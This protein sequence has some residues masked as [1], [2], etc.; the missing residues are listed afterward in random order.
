MEDLSF[1][2]MHAYL[3][4]QFQNLPPK[5]AMEV[6]S[7]VDFVQQMFEEIFYTHPEEFLLPARRKYRFL[8]PVR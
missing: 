8:S 6:D 7:G 2:G 1:K 3:V 4:D 5:Q